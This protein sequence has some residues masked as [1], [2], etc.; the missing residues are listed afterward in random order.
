MGGHNQTPY[1]SHQEA[2]RTCWVP[3]CQTV[4]VDDAGPRP[5]DIGSPAG[6]RITDAGDSHDY[7]VR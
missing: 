2:Q 5:P 1:L 6:D 7:S 3:T 4:V